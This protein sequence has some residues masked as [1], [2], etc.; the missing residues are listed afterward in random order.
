MEEN[1]VAEPNQTFR[2]S[3]IGGR[4]GNRAKEQSP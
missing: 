4:E 1:Y 2:A 3:A